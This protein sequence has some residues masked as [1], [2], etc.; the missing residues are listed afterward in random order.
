M[1]TQEVKSVEMRN[2][3]TVAALEI[4]RVSTQKALDEQLAEGAEKLDPFR[5]WLEGRVEAFAKAIEL[6]GTL[7]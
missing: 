4:Y 6:I 7:S 2:A 3:R 1:N 5:N